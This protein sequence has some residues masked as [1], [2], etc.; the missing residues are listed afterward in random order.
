VTFKPNRRWILGTVI[1]L[2]MVTTAAFL[3]WFAYEVATKL[4]PRFAACTQ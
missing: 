1:A 3:P 4:D 2:A